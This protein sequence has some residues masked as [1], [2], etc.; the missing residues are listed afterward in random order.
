[1]NAT[2]IELSEINVLMSDQTRGNEFGDYATHRASEGAVAGAVIGRRMGER[3]GRAVEDEIRRQV[4]EQY[5]TEDEVR[6]ALRT[7]RPS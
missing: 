7:S 5:P 6:N 4:A 2:M 3:L 1:M